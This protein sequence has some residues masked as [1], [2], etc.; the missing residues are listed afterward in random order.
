MGDGTLYVTIHSINNILVEVRGDTHLG[1]KNFDK[2]LLQYYIKKFKAQKGI[3]IS[4]N[5]KT[6]SRLIWIC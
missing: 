5:Q 1:G 4:D 6:L 2:R 3:D